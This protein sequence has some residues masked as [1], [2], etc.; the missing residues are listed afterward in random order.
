MINRHKDKVP[1]SLFLL[2]RKYLNML[3]EKLILFEVYLYILQIGQQYISCMPKIAV[4][5][6]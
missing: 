2:Q 4:Y 1:I 3:G 5:F 6:S